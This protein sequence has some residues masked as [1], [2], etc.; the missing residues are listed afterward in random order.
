MRVQEIMTTGVVT[1]TPTAPVE[2]ARGLMRQKGIKHLVVRDGSG[3]VGVLSAR[4]LLRAQGAVGDVMTRDVVTVAPTETVKKAAN[5]MRGRS[6]GSLVV[7]A[8]ERPVG[9]IT[10][11]DLLQ[12]IG[13]SG[14]RAVRRPARPAL[15]HRAPHRKRHTSTGAW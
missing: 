12:L 4:D 8:G 6:I 9:I 11:S 5:M 10:A 7:I 13:E 15:R 14:A 2:T 3:V 1:T